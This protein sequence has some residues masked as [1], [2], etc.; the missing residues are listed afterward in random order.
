MRDR[1]TP[2]GWEAIDLVREVGSQ[3]RA[4]ERLGISD[5]AVSQRLKSAVWSV[6]DEARPGL[7]RLLADLD[8]AADPSS[9]RRAQAGRTGDG[10]DR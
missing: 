6:D 10:G 4:A 2:Q 1:R 9:R 5:A 8:R 3:K 7:V